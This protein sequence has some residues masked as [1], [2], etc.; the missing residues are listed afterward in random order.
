MPLKP[1]ALGSAA[2]NVL[3]PSAA[4]DGA[5]W[6]V[7]RAALLAALGT[8]EAGLSAAE[9]SRR[10]DHYRANDAARVKRSPLWLQLLGR[11]ANPLIAILLIASLLS[12][13]TGDVASFVI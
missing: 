9:A 8:S 1:L 4:D 5:F 12:A 11:F 2:A 13:V 10:L 6:L 3:S 7:P